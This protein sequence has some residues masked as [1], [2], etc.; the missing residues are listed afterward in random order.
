MKKALMIFGGLFLAILVAV[1][2]LVGYGAFQGGKLDA[3][4]KTY[5]EATLPQIL[6]D[7][8]AN[9]ILSFFAPQDKAKLNSAAIDQFALKVWG[10]LGH[11]QSFDDLKGDSL[12]MYT[13]SGADIK[14]KYV[15]RC[16]YEKGSVTATITLRKTGESWSLIGVNIDF[17]TLEPKPT[18]P[19]Q[20]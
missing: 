11:F 13:L 8:S 1:G 15:A 2:G 16:H 4:S 17:D 7:P 10:A 9:N 3:E 12:A 18:T 6:A 19:S 20:A 5:V 14:A